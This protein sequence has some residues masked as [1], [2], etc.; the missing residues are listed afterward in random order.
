[1]I[2]IVFGID[3]SY[4]L[5][6]FVVMYSIVINSKENFHFVILTTDQIEEE[7]DE[8]GKILSEVCGRIVLEIKEV[9]GQIFDNVPIYNPHLSKASYFRLLIPDLIPEYDKCLYLDSDILINGDI[10]EIFEIDVEDVY[11]GGVRDCHLALSQNQ[12]NIPLHQIRLGIAS[13]ENYVNAGVLLLNLKR[14]RDQKLVK[15]F[16]E[17]AKKE[18]PY[19]DQDVLNVCCYGEV[20]PL[21]AKYNLFHIYTGNAMKYLFEGP[22][23]QEEFLFHWNSPVIVHMIERYKPW[24]NR[25]YKGAE[26]WWKMAEIYQETSYYQTLSRQCGEPGDDYREMKRILR[27]CR[28]DKKVILWGYTEQGKDVYNVF[29]RRG[30]SVYAFCDNDIRKQKEQYKGIFVQDIGTLMNRKEEFIWVIT[31]KNTNAYIAVHAQLVELD[32]P[33]SD[34]F[35][36]TFNSR[37][38]KDYLALDPLYYEEEVRIIALCENDQKRLDDDHYLDYINQVV[39][40]ADIDDDMYRYLYRK[41]RFDLWLNC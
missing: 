41:Y 11:L 15:R 16:L 30:I 23:S 20:K 40:K 21:P 3:Q 22:Y 29:Q 36:F 27:A 5:Q 1:M 24:L 8:L 39:T 9:D 4:V 34:I 28:T 19:E 12:K 35:H 32:I 14:M 33:V 31:C 17:Q 18:N 37:S 38:R 10:Q 26:Q 25:K 13:M 2:P 7:V 6:V